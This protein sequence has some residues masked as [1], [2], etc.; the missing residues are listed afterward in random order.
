MK[1][2]F[3]FAALFLCASLTSCQCADQPDVG[4]VEGEDASAQVLQ[5]DLPDRPWVA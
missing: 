1:R 3:V 4:P 5:E 2:S